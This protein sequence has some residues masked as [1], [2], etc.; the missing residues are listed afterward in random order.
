M[1]WQCGLLSAWLSHLVA[2]RRHWP[3]QHIVVEPRLL[4]QW[5][6]G[7]SR[8]GWWDGR[9]QLI[10]QREARSEKSHGCVA[11]DVNHAL[12][13]VRPPLPAR[14]A[15]F[16]ATPP[17]SGPAH[18]RQPT[19][20]LQHAPEKFG[21]F[22]RDVV[23]SSS[24]VLRSACDAQRCAYFVAASTSTTP[25]IPHLTPSPNAFYSHRHSDKNTKSKMVIRRFLLWTALGSLCLEATASFA[26]FS[27]MTPRFQQQQQ[28]SQQQRRNQRRALVVASGLAKKKVSRRRRC[29]H[30]LKFGIS[31]QFPHTLSLNA[32]RWW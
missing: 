2:E 16:F 25:S 17:S 20:G 8:G 10:T 1:E 27:K 4:H 15:K 14:R 5:R 11:F 30:L 29:A 7:A 31:W 26:G 13:E 24:D 21:D 22:C 18:H 3:G 32:R 23:G 19:T 6:R 12:R 9:C 28:Q